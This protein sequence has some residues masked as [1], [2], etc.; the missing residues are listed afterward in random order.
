MSVKHPLTI[1]L[2]SAAFRCDLL[3]V[4]ALRGREAISQLFSFQISILCLD[5][6]GLPRDEVVGAEATI[7]MERDGVVL[8]RVH[9]MIAELVDRLEVEAEH[10]SYDLLLVPRAWRLT[11]VETQEILMDLT[12]PQMIQQK[13]ELV[14]IAS[15]VQQRLLEAYPPREFVVQ[16]RESDLAFISRLAEHLG[17][18][19]FFEHGEE[20]EVL[21]LTDHMEGFGA[22][23]DGG[24]VPFRP[25]GEQRDV[26]SLE[27]KTRL[28]PAGYVVQDYNYR[29]PRIDLTAHHELPAA[30]A[31]GV[32]EYGTHFKTPEEGKFFARVRAEERQSTRDVYVGESDIPAFGAGLRFTLEGHPHVQESGLLLVEVEHEANQVV[33]GH[34]GVEGAPSYRNSFRAIPAGRAYRPPRITPRPRIHGLLSGVVESNA[35]GRRARIDPKGRYTVQFHFDTAAG[36]GA[37]ASRPVRMA[38]PHAGPGYGM[39]FPVKP[40]TEVLLGFIDGDPDRPIIVGAIPNESAPSP[41]T[42]SNAH[43]NQIRTVSGIVVELDDYV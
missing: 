38:Q 16:Y 20:R 21:V 5:P 31:G 28:I 37:K 19:F 8:R 25:R 35:V 2:E 26:F 30:Y 22:V 29:H 24:D 15:D 27:V 23:G 12:I 33:G 3:R 40:G 4:R 39:H 34:G 17:I 42:A 1:R 11:L 36:G 13:I 10:R 18:S 7:V 41:V 6:E 32:V 9:G 43:V 14:G